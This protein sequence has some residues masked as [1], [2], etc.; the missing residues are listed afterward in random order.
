MVRFASLTIT[1]EKKEVQNFIQLSAAQV[2]QVVAH[3]TQL[4]I[5]RLEQETKQILA[6]EETN[7]SKETTK[8]I[9]IAEKAVRLVAA[10]AAVIACVAFVPGY[11]GLGTALLMGALFVPGNSVRLM[12]DKL[13]TISLERGD[14]PQKLPA[15]PSSAT[16]TLP[17]K[18]PPASGPGSP[19]SPSA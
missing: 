1:F 8:R 6:Q 19:G 16:P 4:E 5:A 7:R 10:S 13:G 9:E 17:E 18:T 14:S 2:E 11:A 3:R 15:T 12:W